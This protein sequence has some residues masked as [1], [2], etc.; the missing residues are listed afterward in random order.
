MDEYF[1]QGNETI[2]RRMFF[3]KSCVFSQALIMHALNIVIFVIFM[4]GCEVGIN[5]EGYSLNDTDFVDMSVCNV[6][7]KDS[8]KYDQA[9]VK[10]L[11][12]INAYDAAFSTECNED[13]VL[14]IFR[15]EACGLGADLINITKEY[16]PDFWSTCYRAEAELLQFND[17]LKLF[18]ITSDPKYDWD[19]V[20]ERSRKAEIRE[21]RVITGAIIGGAVGG[22]IGGI[23]E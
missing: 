1:R 23:A 13:Q 12:K 7:V 4:G 16:Q 18:S 11:G 2:L 19:L 22:V 5:R 8:Y 20:V 15:R 14:M 21:K 3:A 9:D 17:K 6:R 10:L